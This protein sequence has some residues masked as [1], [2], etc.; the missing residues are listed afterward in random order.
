MRESG[1]ALLAEGALLGVRPRIQ[2]P[3]VAALVAGAVYY[4][5]AKIGLALTFDPFPLSVLWPPNALLLGCLLLAPTRWWWLL[6]AAAFPA[7]LLAELQGGVPLAM[8]LCWFVSN[9]VEALIG[10]LLLRR[11]A[12]R[13]LTLGT[14][15]HVV[16]FCVAAVLA[17]LLSS[18]L[19]AAFVRFIG[20][21][22]AGYWSLWNAR[23]FSNMLATLT[24]VPIALT[25]G[26]AGSAQLRRIVEGNL[27]EAATL[28]VGLLGVSF[29]AFDAVADPSSS[30]SLL[31]L[32]I[33]FLLWAALR[34][35][36]QM[37]S[38]G[39]AVVVFSVIWGAGHGRG[40]FLQAASRDDAF[41]IQLFLISI[42][43]PM[44]LLAAVIE[45]RRRVND[46]FSTAFRSSPDAIAIS[47]R[48]DGHVLEANDCGS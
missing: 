46:L 25:W 44:L 22:D 32:P 9:V 37:T 27:L 39:F 12:G 1:R 4:I 2:R 14:V 48:S 3:L 41:P 11:S 38:A 36:P 45:E 6:I 43:V 13:A 35:G 17:P 31:Y 5:G 10:A 30:T 20:W 18:F 23:V 29:A 8:V 26:T 42:A 47:R 34:F 19:D 40:P 7:H 16:M 21:R 15:R 28:L 24:F 33:P